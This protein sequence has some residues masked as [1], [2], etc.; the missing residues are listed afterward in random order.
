MTE[1][2][3]AEFNET[4]WVAFPPDPSIAAWADAALPYGVAAAQ[5]PNRWDTQLRCGGTWFVGLDALPND[6]TGAV[7]GQAL[8]SAALRFAQAQAP[9]PLPL[10]AAQISVIYPGYPKPMAGESE[11]AFRFR[12]NRD[13]AHLDGLLPIGPDKRR[14]LKECHAYIL[15]VPL[16]DTSPDASPLV[17]WEGSHE[18]IRS[19]FQEAFDGVPAQDWHDQDVT[20]LYQQTRRQIFETCSRVSIHCPVGGAYVIHRLALHGVAPW[21]EGATAPGTG[22]M[23]AYFR[24]EL[25]LTRDWLSLH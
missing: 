14:M 7:E 22:R 24:P 15:G 23:I 3:Q 5:D 17:V 16:T 1:A 12:K 4:G 21:A 18:I 8:T 2:L 10:H 19:A 9:R 13:A 11:A 6:A 25:P 20:D